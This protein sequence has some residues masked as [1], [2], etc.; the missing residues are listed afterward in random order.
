MLSNLLNILQLMNGEAK[1]P[2]PGCRLLCSKGV[3]SI[4]VEEYPQKNNQFIKQTMK[5]SKFSTEKVFCN[6]NATY[7]IVAQSHFTIT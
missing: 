3:I 5:C 7:N 1:S 6:R 4:A 2:P